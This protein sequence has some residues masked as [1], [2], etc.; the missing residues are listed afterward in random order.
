MG[1][2]DIFYSQVRSFELALLRGDW[3]LPEHTGSDYFLDVG[4]DPSMASSGACAI[5][6]QGDTILEVR[7]ILH[8][9]E[10]ATPTPIRI[11]SVSHAMLRMIGDITESVQGRLHITLMFEV[12]PT[13]MSSSGWLFALNQFLW[14]GFSSTDPLFQSLRDRG[15]TITFHQW[16]IGVTQLKHLYHEISDKYAMGLSYKEIRSKKSAVVSVIQRVLLDIPDL[17]NK[18]PKRF[19]NDVAEGIILACLA[20]GTT[21]INS[22][23]VP[24]ESSPYAPVSLLD[25]HQMMTN[26]Q[27]NKKNERLGW[28]F[29]PMVHCFGWEI[30]STG[31]GTV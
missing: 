21:R 8:K 2:A 5:L 23:K 19:N 20:G 18:L 26:K 3:P 28:V 29:R 7:T 30:L 10:P 27:V 15:V 14:V 25:L 16:A 4:L 24:T 22:F 13:Q 1:A 17:K 11:D 31:S 12:P 9:T 6:R